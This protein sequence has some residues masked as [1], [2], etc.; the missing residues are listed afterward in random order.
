MS[1]FGLGTQDPTKNTIQTTTTAP[2]TTTTTTPTPTTTTTTTTTTRT[3][4][5]PLISFPAW[6]AFASKSTNHGRR[7][8]GRTGHSSRALSREA[9]MTAVTGGGSPAVDV[10]EAFGSRELDE[11]QGGRSIDKTFS[12]L[13]RR[14][15]KLS[16]RTQCCE[17]GVSAASTTYGDFGAVWAQCTHSSEKHVQS[18]GLRRGHKIC[19]TQFHRCCIEVSVSTPSEVVTWKPDS[20]SSAEWDRDRHQVNKLYLPPHARLRP[21]AMVTP[22][23]RQP[24]VS[25]R[26][27]T[28]SAERLLSVRQAALVEELAGFR[29]PAYTRS[30]SRFV[31]EP[32]IDEE[33]QLKRRHS[34]RRSRKQNSRERARATANL[35]NQEKEKLRREETDEFDEEETATKRHTRRQRKQNS[36]ERLGKT[37]SRSERRSDDIDDAGQERLR[38]ARRDLSDPE[39]EEEPRQKRPRRPKNG[40]RSQGKKPRQEPVQTNPTR[41]SDVSVSSSQQTKTAEPATESAAEKR[42]HLLEVEEEQLKYLFAEIAED[43]DENEE[44]IQEEKGDDRNELTDDETDDRSE[45]KS[46]DLE[47]DSENADGEDESEDDVSEE[48]DENDDDVTDDED[49]DDASVSL[50]NNVNSKNTEE[51]TPKDKALATTQ[52]RPTT[53]KPESAK[54]KRTE[55]SQETKSTPTKRS[56]AA[57]SER[58]ARLLQTRKGL[59]S[60][61]GHS[62]G[63]SGGRSA[64]RKRK[65]FNARRKQRKF[66]HSRHMR[67]GHKRRDLDET[68]EED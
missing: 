53:K 8:G 55:V 63:H 64:R 61:D 15:W 47:V 21:V 27:R 40:G 19:S 39:V 65:N 28:S 37:S 68:V 9:T 12:K 44:E 26:R 34:S 25:Q 4:V 59:G 29:Q 5:N 24:D 11:Q 1:L 18:K 54:R 6:P 10:E 13:Q 42:K 48:S 45:D 32:E 57:S 3:T 38:A 31:D 7:R 56:R 52:R 33:P 2:T 66:R 35:V 62:G 30:S 23:Q 22:A 58:T 36:R 67:G 41:P 49:T 51:E 17:A 60:E 50:S 16:L 20:A 43:I 14:M 46:D